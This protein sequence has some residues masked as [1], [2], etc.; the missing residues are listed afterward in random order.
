MAGAWLLET[1]CVYLV[2]S[3]QTSSSSIACFNP[4]RC[5]QCLAEVPQ[6]SAYLNWSLKSLWT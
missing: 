6:T 1:R 4:T 2:M 5:G 3:W